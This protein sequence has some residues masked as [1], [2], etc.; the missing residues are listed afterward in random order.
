[1][2]DL[3]CRLLIRLLLLYYLVSSL[4]IRLLLLYYLIGCLLIRLLLL[5]LDNF[6]QFMLVFIVNEVT[7]R[8]VRTEADRVVRTTQ[9][10][11]VLGVSRE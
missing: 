3:V 2:Y 9:V 11:L 7:S 10:G 8:P 6:I 1:L 4:L 5:Q